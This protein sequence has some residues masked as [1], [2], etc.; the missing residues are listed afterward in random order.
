[1]AI[2]DEVTVDYDYLKNFDIKFLKDKYLL[3]FYN[4]DYYSK[5]AVC[6][7]TCDESMDSLS[8]KL[9]KKKFVKTQD[10]LF[11]LDDFELKHKLFTISENAVLNTNEFDSKYFLKTLLS[12]ALDKK[13]SDIHI[14]TELD[15]LKIKFRIDGVLKT[16]F[17]FDIEFSDILASL[18]KLISNLD[19]TQKRVPQN[20]RFEMKL[21]DKDIDFRVSTMPTIK[22]ESIVL[23]IL[24]N[25]AS[26]KELEQLDLKDNDLKIISRNMKKSNGLILVTGPTGSGK[27][28]TLYSILN[29]LNDSKK[30]IITIEDPVEY[31]IKGVQQ[32]A[33]NNEI[34]LR[35]E[36]V[37]K[38]ILRQDPDVIMIG[39]IRDKESLHIAIQA[40][41][42]GHLVFSTLHTNDSISTISRLFDLEAKPYLVANTLR[43]VIAQRLVLKLCQNCES[44]CSACNYTRFD[45]R[46]PLYE[47][48]EVDDDLSTAIY[49]ASGKTEIEKIVKSKDFKTL[50][51][52]AKEKIDRK[53]TT[54]EEVS[55][56]L[57]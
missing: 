14:E 43:M 28:T 39:E 45:G 32:V 18:I 8:N 23:R 27:S 55:K 3:P 25:T 47:I 17:S 44:G 9:I 4:D 2:L 15:S 21:N 38:N 29:E 33:I 20:A 31:Q 19:I 40:S 35:F 12:F 11:C 26:K 37:L 34:G 10:I 52:D 50:M 48:L 51:E 54:I 42:T 30:K 41:L 7:F 16:F 53:L 5:I 49:K 24:D 13:S 56:V 46:V 22:G 1:M 57:F 6:E 36:E